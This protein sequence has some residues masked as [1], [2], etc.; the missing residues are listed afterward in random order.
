M[1]TNKLIEHALEARGAAYSPY[2]GF[3]VGA[4]LLGADGVVYTGCNIESAAFSPTI[5]AE[6]VA[7]AKAISEGCRDFAALAIVGGPGDRLIANCFPCGVCRQVMAEFCGGD[8]A[9]IIAGGANNWRI[10]TLAELLPH[11]FNAESMK[12]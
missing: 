5:C 11:V 6:R 9:V 10:V 1:D 8:F 4:A 3:R 2:S 7:I 12:T